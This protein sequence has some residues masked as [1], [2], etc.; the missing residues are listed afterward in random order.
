MVIKRTKR[1][2]VPLS[3]QEWRLVHALAEQEGQSVSNW[4]RQLVRAAAAKKS[5]TAKKSKPKKSKR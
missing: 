4:V 5:K 1:L 2:H 3:V